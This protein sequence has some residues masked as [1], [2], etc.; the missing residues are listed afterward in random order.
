M[1]KTSIIKGRTISNAKGTHAVKTHKYVIDLDS[2]DVW[3]SMTD[4]AE[5]LGCNV[6]TVSSCCNG[7][8]RTCKGRHLALATDD[9][10]DELRASLKAKDTAMME[11]EAKLRI[12]KAEV[13]NQREQISELRQNVNESN[14]KM[15][16]AIRK[17]RKA[18]EEYERVTQLLAEA[19][20]NYEMATV[21]LE[22]LMEN[23]YA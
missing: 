23:L 20:Y 3:V 18:K 1:K 7:K 9:I 4:C 5:E 14:E 13:E 19:A 10:V 22:E 12:I 8:L 21:E 15:K 11:Q 17:K 2:G 16:D 6:A